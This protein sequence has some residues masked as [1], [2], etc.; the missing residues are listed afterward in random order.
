M[1]EYSDSLW[2]VL[3]LSA[4]SAALNAVGL[5][6][7]C[8][9][10]VAAPERGVLVGVARGETSGGVAACGVTQGGDP[11]GELVGEGDGRLRGELGEDAESKV[12]ALRGEVGGDVAGDP[13]G[14]V[15]GDDA[16]ET[17][18]DVTGRSGCILLGSNPV[19]C[20]NATN[21]CCGCWLWFSAYLTWGFTCVI[22]E[23]A[24]GP[25]TVPG[26][27]R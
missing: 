15:G 19:A 22:G 10:V 23:C 4:K 1:C 25:G 11:R 13:K 24:I 7:V 8:A 12:C 5:N 2:R 16:G 17:K 18:G 21:C 9:A 20:H 14:E 26:V 27:M 3:T 6:V